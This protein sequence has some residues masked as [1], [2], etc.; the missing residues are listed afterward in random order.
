MA[1]GHRID[2]AGWRAVLDEVRAR[3]AG[4]FARVE[5]RRTAGD[6][7]A[8]LLSEIESKTCWG[9]AEQAGHLRPD[10]MQRLLR[11]AVWDTDGVRDDVRQ[12]VVDRFG[13]PQAVLIPDETGDLKKGTRSVG[14]QRQYSGTAG[15]IENAQ[16]AV[17]VTY[18]S[19]HGHTL[20]DR[21]LYLPRSWTDDR[22]RCTAAGVPEQVRFATKP[23]LAG[24]MIDA[25]VRAGT[26]AGWVAADEAYGNDP[27]FRGRVR[28]HRLGYVLAVSCDHR[29]HLDAKVR[30][31]ADQVAA[32]LPASAWQRRSAGT[33]SKGPRFYD[34]A[35]L[36]DIERDPDSGHHSML[37]RRTTRPVSWPSTAAGHP[38]RARSPHSSPSPG[39]AGRSRNPSKPRKARSASTSTKSGSG[40]AGSASPSW[41]SPL[42]RSWPS[43]P[44]PPRPRRRQTPTATPEA[45]TARS[46][47]RSTR[48][49]ACSTPSSS[50]RPATPA[51]ASAGQSG[52]PGT[53][54]EPDEPT[55]N[56]DS[57]SNSAH[58]HK[59]RLPY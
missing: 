8:G 15:R 6:F 54:P 24:D 37:I 25:A 30:I 52:A 11:T 14:V 47:G 51:T 16:V 41:P 48:S 49:A 22:D 5:P 42:S 20:I 33:G 36:T 26:P 35:W 13:D 9:L 43:A 59:V 57:P 32:G 38:A 45:T 28:G 55:T 19:R 12:L 21:R 53:K 4:R 10:K 2:P 29:I 58:D 44:T 3:I 46:A 1:A 34:W 39:S 23:Q 27:A 31:R 18:A 56:D 7:L 50:P 17:F 40:P